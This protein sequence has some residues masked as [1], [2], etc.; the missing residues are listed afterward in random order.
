VLSDDLDLAA[1]RRELDDNDHEFAVVLDIDQR[2]RGYLRRDLAD[3]DGRVG[4]RLRRLDAWVRNT[5]TLK[6]ALG[7]MLLYDAGWVA[8]LDDDD[9]FLGVLTP[10]SLYQ[11][12]RRSLD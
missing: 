10:E 11:A 3:G 1:A 12:T 4:D 2:L 6:D 5:D 7:E 9:R 8:V